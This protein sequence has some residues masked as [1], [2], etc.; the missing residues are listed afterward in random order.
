MFKTHTIGSRLLFEIPRSELGKEMLI[1]KRAV[2]VRS[3]PATAVRKSAH[4][5]WSVE[6]MNNR[7]LL[8]TVSTPP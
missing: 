6:R 4:A 7:I 3:T 5:T 2:R 8:R 1:V